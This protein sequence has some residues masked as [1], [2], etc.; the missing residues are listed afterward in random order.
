MALSR[1]GIAR[2]RLVG[3]GSTLGG[4]AM[5]AMPHTFVKQ[6]QYGTVTIGNSVATGT[7]TITSVDVNHSLLFFLGSSYDDTESSQA[8]GACRVSLTNATTVTA[9][10][11]A[12]NTAAEVNS[13]N[14]CVIEFYPGVLRSVQRGTISLASDAD[15]DA[16]ITAV[17]TAKAFVNYLGHSSSA[18]T[19]DNQNFYHKLTLSAAT[20]VNATRGVASSNTAIVGYQVAEFY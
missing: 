3:P 2:D 4:L 17:N 15:V 8:R 6:V 10:Q 5:H 14:F 7:A 13:V 18:A 19:H 11:S 1:G 16:T 9:D 20:T 12:A